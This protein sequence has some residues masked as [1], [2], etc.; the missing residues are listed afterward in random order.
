M[1]AEH[2]C[3]HAPPHLRQL[4]LDA[5]PRDVPHAPLGLQE[6]VLPSRSKKLLLGRLQPGA[7]LRRG[8]RRLVPSGLG[9]AQGLA[10]RGEVLPRFLEASFESCGKKQEFESSRFAGQGERGLYSCLCFF[11]AS[12][13][14]YCSQAR[15]RGRRQVHE[16]PWHY[17]AKTAAPTAQQ[18]DVKTQ[19]EINHTKVHVV[20][21]RCHHV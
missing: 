11:D 19:D 5:A 21:E 1:R 8:R 4:L 10:N 14:D 6:V 2:L 7:G 9:L 16:V 12:R 17:N 20:L 13:F 18:V 15:P 3:R